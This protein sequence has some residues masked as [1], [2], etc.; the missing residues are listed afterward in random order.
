MASL[1]N[2]S[3]APL[4]KTLYT[5]EAIKQLVY[6]NNPFFAM[7]DKD[8]DFMGDSLKIPLIWADSQNRS[9][10]FANANVN[11]TTLRSSAFFITSV[12]DYSFATVANKTIES[13]RGNE[14]AFIR[15]LKQSTDSALRTLSR[16][17]CTKMYRSGTGAV[18]QIS[19]TSSLVGT[20]LATGVQLSPAE[21]I[22]NLEVGMSIAFAATD[23]GTPV[24]GTAYIVAIDRI[25]GR[26]LCSATPTGA[27]TAL[28]TLVPTVA[29]S[30]YVYQSVGD[31]NLAISGLQAWLPGQNVSATPFF[32]VNRQQGDATRLAGIYYTPAPGTPLNEA[33]IQAMKYVAREGGNPTHVMVDFETFASL[34]ILFGAKQQLIDINVKDAKAHFGFMGLIVN[35]PTGFVNIIPDVNCPPN[36]AF[37]LQ[38][39]TWKMHSMGQAVRIFNTDGLT[40]IRSLTED[41]VKFQCFSYA[42]MSCNAPGWNAQVLFQ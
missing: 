26:F 18:A 5:N 40:V 20:T 28:S 3:F 22:T 25:N 39:D 6:K 31:V 9:N 24:A 16:S 8:E 19:A 32:Q 38:M 11:D 23:G 37:V 27:P 2:T 41:A 10:T 17:I 30:Y 13:S 14:G 36:S 1:D 34:E 12:N 15:A 29:V 7:I 21:N 35:G 42:Q 4:L 33:I